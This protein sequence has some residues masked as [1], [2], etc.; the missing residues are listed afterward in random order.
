MWTAQ[1]FWTLKALRGAKK[2]FRLTTAIP[3]AVLAA[4]LLC[5]SAGHAGTPKAGPADCSFNAGPCT[6]TAGALTIVLDISPKPLK[7]MREL[8]FTATVT[9]QGKP[10]SDAQLLIELTM[11]GMYMGKNVVRLAHRGNGVYEG[12]GV[13]IRCPKGEKL[14]QA[15]VT[16]ERPA[17]KKSVVKY[18]FEVPS[19]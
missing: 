13:I 7:V 5:V 8:T 6:K 10:V 1:R 18:L 14:W 3:V 17:R 15:A 11:P 2:R 19:I 9:D 12:T 4:F 16:V